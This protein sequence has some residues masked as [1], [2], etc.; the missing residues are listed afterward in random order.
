[1]QNNKFTTR[2]LAKMAMCIA[3]IS[4]AGYITFPL[5]FTPVMVTATTA[6]M[7][8]TALILT[9]KETF[10]TLVAYLLLGGVAGL[11]ILPGGLSGLGRILG[12]SGGFYFAWIPAFTLVSCFKG[13]EINFKR[14]A[15]AAVCISI[16]VVDAGGVISM[17]MSLD[18]NLEMALAQAVLPFIPGDIIKGILAAFIAV[19]INKSI[20]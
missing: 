19:K 11:P 18:I 14:Y 13:R 1:M 6:A 8:L 10:F 9:P 4:V 3:V 7:A 5:P 2:S 15:L 12:P 20:G 17:M 16:P